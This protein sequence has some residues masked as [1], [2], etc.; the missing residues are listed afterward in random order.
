[1][2]DISSYL[3][4]TM[5]MSGCVAALGIRSFH[6]TSLQQSRRLKLIRL[7]MTLRVLAAQGKISDRSISYKTL[8]TL[9]NHSADNVDGLTLWSHFK[10]HINLKQKTREQERAFSKF[11]DEMNAADP[12]VQALAIDFVV[13]ERHI[14]IANS[15]CLTF[16]IFCLHHGTKPL[17][18]LLDFAKPILA[19]KASAARYD[20]YTFYERV[21]RDLGALSR[22]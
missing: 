15:L 12:D 2:T 8:D 3:G 14:V 11:V 9:L 19:S 13:T 22:A 17:R 21:E 7:G 18:L 5:L 16:V 10:N 1:M 20:A 6:H 4:A